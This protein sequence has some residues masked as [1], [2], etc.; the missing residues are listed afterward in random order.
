MLFFYQP[1]D[2]RVP[3]RTLSF[4]AIALAMTGSGALPLSFDRFLVGGYAFAKL[5]FALGS[6]ASAVGSTP[7][8][9]GRSIQQL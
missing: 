9:D 5:V 3:G 2:H 6:S 1:L 8:Q 7:H 4:A